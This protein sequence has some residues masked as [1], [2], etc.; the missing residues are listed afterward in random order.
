MICDRR[1]VVKLAQENIIELS[2]L[3]NEAATELL[4]KYLACSGLAE[5]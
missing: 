1:V 5:N 2:E 4:K 3:D